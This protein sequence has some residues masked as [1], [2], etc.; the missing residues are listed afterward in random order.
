MPYCDAM[1]VDGEMHSLLSDPR[2]ARELMRETRVFSRKTCDEFIA[3]VENLITN[4]PADHLARV[5]RVYG[6]DYGE[7]FVGMYD[8]NRES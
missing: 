8:T 3:Y 4:A 6:D 2:A 7:P 5:R 1:Y